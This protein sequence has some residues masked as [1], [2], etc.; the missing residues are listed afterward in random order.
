MPCFRPDLPVLRVIVGPTAAGKSALAL[1]LATEVQASIISADS[2]QAY[3]GFDIGTAKASVTEQ[4]AVPHFGLDVVAPDQRFSAAQ[5]AEKTVQWVGE[6]QTAGRS[7][8]IVGGTG[9]Y[10]RALFDPFVEVPP[11][12]GARRNALAAVLE[13]FPGAELHRWCNALDPSRAHLGRTQQLRAIETALLLGRRLSDLHRSSARAP[14]LAPRYLLVDPGRSLAERVEHRV[15]QM[16]EAGWLAEVER[17]AT[18]VPSD[19]PAWG[20]TGYRDLRRALAGEIT[21][22]EAERRIV[23][24]TRQYA[25][26]QRTWFRN[27]LNASLVTTVDPAGAD[28]MDIV[29]AWWRGDDA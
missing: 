2:R 16:L 25:K 19:A 17:L 4:S 29:H 26:R 22:D 12:D 11:M 13:N 15:R 21:L 9:F 3:R 24:A 14:M 20:A 27:Q 23:V 18:N 5:W 28:V 8:L 10:L 1:R 7:P 6:I